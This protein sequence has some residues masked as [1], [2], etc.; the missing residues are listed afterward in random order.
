MAS[1]GSPD[2]EDLVHAYGIVDPEGPVQLPRAGIGGQ[3]VFLVGVEG[4]AAVVSNLPAEEYG[5]ES[6]RAHADD[7]AWLGDVAAE[8]NAVL[9]EL[10]MT[11]DVL[12]LRL[13]ALYRDIADVERALR[14]ERD[15]FRAALDQVSG[16]LEWGA[17]IFLVGEPAGQDEPDEQP[18]SG[19]DYLLRKAAQAHR[20]EDAAQVRRRL[21]LTAHEELA[22]ASTHAVVNATQDRALTGRD[23]PMLFNAA[24]LVSRGGQDHF[25]SL[26]EEEAARLQAEGMALEVSGPWAAYNFAGR[27]AAPDGASR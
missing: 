17:K 15:E 27:A 25:L 26:A 7:P 4:V 16:H 2:R 1:I 23:E 19:R 3:A 8:H 24:Y 21:I 14:A 9:E 10:T 22:L 20:R 6:W 13:P 5:V 12:P 11:T 18:A